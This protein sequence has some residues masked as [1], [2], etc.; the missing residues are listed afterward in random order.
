MPQR[1]VLPALGGHLDTVWIPAMRCLWVARNIPSPV[2]AR[3]AIILEI[4]DRLESAGLHI[5]V[6][7]PAEWVP[8]LHYRSAE[9]R[10]LS[11]LG[12]W[13]EQGGRRIAVARYFRLPVGR[14]AYLLS[15]TLLASGSWLDQA[16]QRS[17]LLHCH[18]VLPDGAAGRA[19]KRKYGTPYVVTARQGDLLKMARLGRRSAQSR[20][21]VSV[22]R[23]ADAVVVH[24]G[25]ARDELR[26]LGVRTTMI[27]H[28][29]EPTAVALGKRADRLP[30]D[31][32]RVLTV[33][34]MVGGKNVD[35]VVRAVMRYRGP[36]NLTLVVVGDGPQRGVLARIAESDPR[37]RLTGRLPPTEV[38]EQYR[39]ANI[40]ALPCRDETFGLVFVEAASNGN[41]LL[42]LKG[43]GIWDWFA[44]GEEIIY[45][46]G[47]DDFEKKL[48]VLVDD[49]DRQTRIGQAAMDRTRRDFDWD[50]VI[51]RYVELYR[52]VLDAA[53]ASRG[54]LSPGVDP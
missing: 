16:S 46:D 43:E 53:S 51:R 12:P 10:R 33:A 20:L 38:A 14:L 27:P 37:V 49:R 13:Y 32:V 7:H 8:R 50:V 2:Q 18:H 15:G 44:D 4:A 3:N 1:H 34:R 17:D 9:L 39:Q 47:Y 35:W 24:N 21:Y 42:A 30:T 40:F 6:A 29:I 23:E 28:G 41:A 25:R 19:A 5:E 22:L 54:S 36:R 48:H 11:R 45:A 31:G 52:S 26:E